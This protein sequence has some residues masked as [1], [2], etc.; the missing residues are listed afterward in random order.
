M[1]F[2]LY[3]IHFW[4]GR[5]QLFIEKY[6]KTWKYHNN[7]FMLFAKGIFKMKWIF[8][9]M[10]LICL[11]VHKNLTSLPYWEFFD[12]FLCTVIVWCFNCIR[13][14]LETCHFKVYKYFFIV[15]KI[16]HGSQQQM[17]P[18]FKKYLKRSWVWRDMF[19]VTLIRRII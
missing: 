9:C 10:R 17:L 18:T 1:N 12:L 19:S 5:Q 16:L 2:M 6:S 8:E 15:N 14:K 4:G 7:V 11:C 13:W 3:K